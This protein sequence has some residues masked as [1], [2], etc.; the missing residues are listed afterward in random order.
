MTILF[1]SKCK[2]E[3]Q[4]QGHTLSGL[5]AWWFCI[6]SLQSSSGLCVGKY[7]LTYSLYHPEGGEQRRQRKQ[8][9]IQ[10][11]TC[12]CSQP[13][14]TAALKGYKITGIQLFEPITYYPAISRS[15]IFFYSAC[16]KDFLHS[17]ILGQKQ[18]YDSAPPFQAASWRVWSSLSINNHFHNAGKVV[19]LGRLSLRI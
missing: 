2:S 13:Q 14:S 16:W 5:S 6:W 19:S 17:A 11:C 18:R 4:T 3:D 1:I 8:D 10:Q 12:I 9:N 7:G 15:M